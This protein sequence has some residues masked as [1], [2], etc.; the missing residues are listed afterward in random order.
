MASYE[1]GA[2]GSAGSKILLV[3]KIICP[4]GTVLES[5]HRYDFVG[6]VQADGREYF[7]DGG[8]EYQ[9]IGYSDKEYIDCTCYSDDPIEKIREHFTWV[10]YSDKHGE[11]L[12][13][14]KWTLLKDITDE[15]LQAL[16]KWTEDDDPDYLHQLFI[17][18]GGYRF[19]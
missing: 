9:R 15:H 6:H 19:G 10:S 12:D 14:P 18:E 17:L 5:R 16:V 2:N 11:P 7:V 8:L 4:D 1:L 13:E 3:N